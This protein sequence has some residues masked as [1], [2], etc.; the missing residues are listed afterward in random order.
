M[1][2]I[3][4]GLSSRKKQ[5]NKFLLCTT[6]TTSST[7]F[8][9]LVRRLTN[10]TK[11]LLAFSWWWSW[12]NLR[13]LSWSFMMIRKSYGNICYFFGFLHSLLLQPGSMEKAREENKRLPGFSHSSF[14]PAPHKKQFPH[15]VSIRL[16]SSL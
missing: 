13:F 2:K 5:E 4:Y 1:C 11:N 3:Y 10:I 8:N 14:A 7:F 9:L 16:F 12:C 6:K 15:K